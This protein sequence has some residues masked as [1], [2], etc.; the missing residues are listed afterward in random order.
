MS[1]EKVR[2]YLKAFYKFL[3]SFKSSLYTKCKY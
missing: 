2:E 3:S 1:V